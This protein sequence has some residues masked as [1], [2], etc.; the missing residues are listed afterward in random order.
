MLYMESFCKTIEDIFFGLDPK[1]NFYNRQAFQGG[2]QLH[3]QGLG[4]ISATV[5][6][7]RIETANARAPFGRYLTMYSKAATEGRPMFDKILV[8]PRQTVLMACAYNNSPLYVDN[9]GYGFFS[10]LGDLVVTGPTR[11]NV[12]DYRVILVA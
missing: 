2:N 3:D 12:N 4:A 7:T 9:D 10:A 6:D 8:S 1:W 5:R 11:T